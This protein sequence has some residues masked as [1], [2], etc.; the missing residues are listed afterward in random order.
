MKDFLKGFFVGICITFLI[1]SLLLVKTNQIN[2]DPKDY[3]KEVL[4]VTKIFHKQKVI[5][6]FAEKMKAQNNKSFGLNNQLI[7]E[8]HRNGSFLI[9]GDG[10]AWQKSDSYRDSG[11]IRSK[12]SLPSTYK[13]SVVLGNIDYGLDKLKGLKNDPDYAEGPLNENGVYLLAITDELPQA[14]H[15]NDWWHLHR[16]VAI[17]VDN[18]IWGYGKK[19]P[20]FMVYFDKNNGLNAYEGE[21]NQWKNEWNSAIEYEEGKYYRVEIEKTKKEFILRIYSENNMKL[22]EA[23]ISLE[24]IW[25]EDEFHKDYF[26]IGDPHENYYQGSMKIKEI[27]VQF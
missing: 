8:L 19:N 13:V 27:I 2:F 12:D 21:N 17:D 5:E 14:P 22:K 26:V 1:G 6:R 7:F 3:I 15:T 20:V 23:H 18:N 16:K 4:S 10:I 25:N 11:F 9:E 24:E